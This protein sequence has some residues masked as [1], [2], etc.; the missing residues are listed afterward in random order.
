MIV[1]VMISMHVMTTD[2]TIND[3]SDTIRLI[4]IAKL[5]IQLYCLVVACAVARSL[6]LHVKCKM[7]SPYGT[8]Y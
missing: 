8:S 3:N 2:I 5:L 6:H 4:T 1:L 7:R